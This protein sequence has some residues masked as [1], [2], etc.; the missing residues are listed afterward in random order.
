[1]CKY[2]TNGSTQ[3]PKTVVKA[4]NQFILYL[5][6]LNSDHFSIT[7]TAEEGGTCIELV[8]NG[9]VIQVNETNVYDYVRLYAN[10]RLIKT[11]EKS[12]EVI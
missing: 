5:F 4:N 12:L 6:A 8:P 11:H 9:R 10:Y 7:L 2:S 1:M 3:A